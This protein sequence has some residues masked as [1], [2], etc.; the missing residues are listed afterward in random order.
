M[1]TSKLPCKSQMMW[2]NIYSSF[3]LIRIR[4]LILVLK[5]LKMETRIDNDNPS[6][7]FSITKKAFTSFPGPGE[8]ST[9]G[10]N[11]QSSNA[12]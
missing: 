1:S 5:F 3:N 7:S 12:S 8:M 10:Y 4:S 6:I 2:D 9:Q 11:Q